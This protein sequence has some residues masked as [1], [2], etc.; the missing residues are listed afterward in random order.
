M[1]EQ[2]FYI[3][4]GSFLGVMIGWVIYEYIRE[5]GYQSGYWVGRKDGYDMHRRLVQLDKKNE[6]FDYDKN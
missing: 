5:Q 4:L 1:K 3:L 2:L 6:V